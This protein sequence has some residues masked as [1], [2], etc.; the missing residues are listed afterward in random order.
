MLVSEPF[1]EQLKAVWDAANLNKRIAGGYWNGEPPEDQSVKR[2]YLIASLLSEAPQHFTNAGQY[3]KV[4]LELA[5]VA[6][7]IETASPLMN[8]VIAATK[9]GTYVLPTG[10]NLAGLRIGASRWE[11]VDLFWKLTTEF[12]LITGQ[13]K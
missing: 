9:A 1:F 6:D 5:I 3:D 7:I 11:Q 4:V 2:P 10:L 12:W 8:V 13:A